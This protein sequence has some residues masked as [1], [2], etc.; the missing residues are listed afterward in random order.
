MMVSSCKHYI[1][2]S[3]QRASLEITNG[4]KETTLS[5]GRPCKMKVPSSRA[6][7]MNESLHLTIVYL[8]RDESED[9][10]SKFHG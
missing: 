9:L 7:D 8:I 4:G 6:L 2:L 10:E 1:D 5:I 3:S